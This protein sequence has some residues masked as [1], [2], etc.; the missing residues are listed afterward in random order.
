MATLVVEEA[1]LP[2]FPEVADA[3][4]R[5]A[6]D[7]DGGI[8]QVAALI[9]RD[10]A[11]VAAILR[12]ANS[13]AYRG[14]TPTTTLT[15][16]VG[17]MGLRTVTELTVA[18]CMRPTPRHPGIASDLSAAWAL[19][20]ATGGF[21]RKISALRRRQVESAFL[22]GLLHN[23]GALVLINA[24]EPAASVERRYIEIGVQI[25]MSWAMP[26]SVVA[27]VALH[28]DWGSTQSY[29]DEA[30]TTWLARLLAQEL[31]GYAIESRSI[32][33]DPVL[34]WLDIY[35]DDL[36]RLRTETDEIQALLEMVR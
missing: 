36:E 8:D 11:L 14:R 3:I 24:G 18:I 16:A 22:C 27:G 1:E 10:P 32:D 5:A 23:I 4:L 25:A 12:Q 6:D 9:E 35:P 28:R 7:P 31:L 2:P 33:A 30:S 26:A 20:L 19:A 34:E 15:H 21:A 17:R 13:V 29:A